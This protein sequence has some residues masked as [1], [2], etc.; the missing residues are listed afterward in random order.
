MNAMPDAIPR[1]KPPHAKL[2][3]E[4]EQRHYQTDNWAAIRKRI[5]VRDANT[6]QACDEIVAG[7]QAHVDHR[8]PLEDGG[9]DADDNLQ[10]LCWRCH[11]AKTRQEQ[12]RKGQA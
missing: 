1:W 2:P 8:L 9:T 3:R 6:C 12:R 11:G 10:T 7:Q 5:L 4:R